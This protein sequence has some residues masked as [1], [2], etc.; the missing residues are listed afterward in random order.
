[1]TQMRA[2]VGLLLLSALLCLP[3]CQAAWTLLWSDDFDGPSVNTSLW[4]VYANVSE[5]SNQ[6]ELYTATNVVIEHDPRTGNGWLVLQTQQQNVSWEGHKY[7]VTSGRVDTSNKANVTAPARVV[8]SA[9]L[10][11]DSLSS[12][13]HTAHW[14]LGYACWPLG[15]EI[16][17]MECQSPVRCPLCALG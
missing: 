16:D 5:G 7:N 10:Q 17:I 2:R 6:I 9:R 1:M 3:E 15:G 11:P 14:L 4:N 12:G 8:V 13:I